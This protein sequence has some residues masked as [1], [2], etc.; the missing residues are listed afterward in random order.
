MSLR[1]ALLS[2]IVVALLSLASER[3]ECVELMNDNG[4]GEYM[5]SSRW[6]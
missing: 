2:T 5:A 1:F 4:K 3:V 6:R